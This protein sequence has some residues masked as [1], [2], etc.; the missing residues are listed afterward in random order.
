[1]KDLRGKVAFI[2]GAGSGIGLGLAESMATAG[3]VIALADI[4]ATALGSAVALL[5]AT[6]AAVLPMH[7]DVRD[8]KQWTDA[9]VQVETTLGDVSILC[10]N[11][12]VAGSHLPIAQTDF[13]AWSWSFDVNV[14]GVF[15][16]IKTFLPKMLERGLES[17]IV[18]T[19]SLGGFIARPL[20]GAYSATKAALIA[21]CESLRAELA[22]TQVGLSVLCPG[23]VRSSLLDHVDRFA[24][25][26]IQLGEMGRERVEA[27][28][29]GLDPALVGEIVIQGIHEDKFWLFTH[30]ELRPLLTARAEEILAAMTAVHDDLQ[31]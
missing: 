20:N 2:T 5:R 24:P 7:L 3:V 30:S 4:D 9:A 10:C 6:G 14:N 15:H 22:D 31:S 17:H 26:A 11:A 19:A 13:A 16:G 12:G 25:P 8:P 21:L 23:L 27:L 29:Q 1:M 18:V 28:R